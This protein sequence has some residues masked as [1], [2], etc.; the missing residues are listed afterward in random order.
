MPAGITQAGGKAPHTRKYNARGAVTGT[1]RPFRHPSVDGVR[2]NQQRTNGGM[3]RGEML[4]LVR[5]G[6]KERRAREVRY[7][8]FW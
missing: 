2:I 4:L 6:K 5:Y 8:M 1:L 3:R 7:K